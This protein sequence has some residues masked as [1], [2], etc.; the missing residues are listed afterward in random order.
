MYIIDTCFPSDAK[1]HRADIKVTFLKNPQFSVVSLFFGSAGL[2]GC[3]G[4]HTVEKNLRL[5]SYGMNKLSKC[6]PRDAQNLLGGPCAVAVG[7]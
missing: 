2:V 7:G 6:Y 4:R 1:E 3:S 5:W